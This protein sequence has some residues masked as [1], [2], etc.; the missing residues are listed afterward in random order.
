MTNFFVYDFNINTNTSNGIKK[1]ITLNTALFAQKY[2]SNIKQTNPLL[3][4]QKRLFNLSFGEKLN[5]DKFEKTKTQE[6]QQPQKT[7]PAKTKKVS[8]TKQFEQTKKAYDVLVKEKVLPKELIPF[9]EPQID[10]KGKKSYTQQQTKLIEA[11]QKRMNYYMDIAQHLEEEAIAAQDEVSKQVIDLF[12]GK[13]DLGQYVHVRAKS[14]KSIFN[15]LVK[16]FKDEQF[17]GKMMDRLSRDAYKVPYSKLT[18]DRYKEIADT[19]FNG[20]TFT[21]DQ[22]KALNKPYKKLNKDEKA[23]ILME[24]EAKNMEFTP[25]EIEKCIKIFKPSSKEHEKS[26][27]YIKHLIGTRLVLP[28]GNAEELEKVEKY[29]SKAIRYKK[30]KI[31]RL[32]NYHDNYILPYIKYDTAKKWKDAMPGMVLVENSKVRKRNGYTTTQLNIIHPL[33]L[34]KTKSSA[35]DKVSK[36]AQN[37]A[38][39][40][41]LP[42]TIFGEL[43]IRTQKLNDIGQ[44]EHLIYDIL[45]NKDISKGIPELRKYYD[46]IGIEKAVNDVFNDEKK[47][48]NYIRYENSMYYWI[49]HKELRR[50]KPTAEYLKP[51]LNMFELPGYEILD[52]DSLAR[53]DKEAEKIKRK[54]I[55]RT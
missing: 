10:E 18:V 43:Q 41:S 37:I 30:I 2:N 16:E 31:T 49:R 8:S 44:I 34:Q 36:K 45:E 21:E 19:Y 25:E 22:Y 48:E 6:T 23:L 1:V 5:E 55:N 47:E 50:N 51:R 46:S 15:K 39:N 33:K 28:T 26:I 24:L 40:E 12:G 52:F 13:E 53:I 9:L 4:N 11:A 27:N 14:K 29:I 32:S 42:K 35:S 54:F 3:A 7:N 17:Y 20:K 38:K